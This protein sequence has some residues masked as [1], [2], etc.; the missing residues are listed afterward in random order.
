[1]FLSEIFALQL[2][3]LA[4]LAN[5]LILQPPLLGGVTVED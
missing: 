5:R 1:M 3:S 2:D 4:K